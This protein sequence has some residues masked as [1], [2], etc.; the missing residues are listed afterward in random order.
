MG[1]IR[2]MTRRLLIVLG[3]MAT[4]F[5]LNVRLNSVSQ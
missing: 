2:S 3:V 1:G 4:A 5:V